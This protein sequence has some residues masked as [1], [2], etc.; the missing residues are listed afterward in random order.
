MPALESSH[1]IAQAV[2]MAPSLPRDKVILVNLA[3]ATRTCIPSPNAAA[4][5]CDA[6]MT[7][8]DRIAAAF[9]RT[10]ASGRA[11]ALIPIAAGDPSPAATV[12]LMHALVE[13]A[14]TCS[15]WACRFPIPWPTGR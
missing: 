3:V 14:P 12:P 7:R 8:N 6:M 9:A 15:N 10:A 2:K 11:S 5:S 1:A 4:S 13:A